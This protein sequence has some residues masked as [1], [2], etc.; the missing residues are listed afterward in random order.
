MLLGM[1][2]RI[3]LGIGILL[4]MLLEILLQ[5]LLGM[6]LRIPLGIGILLGMLL[7]IFLGMLIG[8]LLGILLG[9]L[10]GMLRGILLGMLRVRDIP[11]VGLYFPTKACTSVW[12][13]GGRF[14]PCSLWNWGAEPVY[15]A[16]LG[17]TLPRIFSHQDLRPN[18]EPME[19]KIR[20][21]TWTCFS[22]NRLQ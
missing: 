22:R 18:F 6:L 19:K 5:I 17:I 16:S 13:A 11:R 3:L 20:T 7:G 10:R 12:T 21:E 8:I 15:C 4:G 2:L 1:L 9:M 14:N